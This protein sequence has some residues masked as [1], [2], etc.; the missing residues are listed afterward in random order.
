MDESPHE[1]QHRLDMRKMGEI[2][3]AMISRT[4]MASVTSVPGSGTWETQV[5]RYNQL[6]ALNSRHWLIK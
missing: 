6:N 4:N 1:S 2:P 5:I 3:H